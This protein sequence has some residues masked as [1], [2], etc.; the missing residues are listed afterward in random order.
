MQGVEKK[1]KNIKGVA[2][3]NKIGQQNTICVYND[4]KKPTF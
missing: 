1:K 2:L 3:Q 4:S